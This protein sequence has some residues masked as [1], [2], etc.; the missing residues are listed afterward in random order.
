MEPF[1]R[2]P[3]ALDA[4]LVIGPPADV[5][6]DLASRCAIDATCHKPPSLTA[7]SCDE[8]GQPRCPQL[9]AVRPWSKDSD[10][11]LLSCDTPPST[12]AVPGK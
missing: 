7:C 11:Q 12:D 2:R 9:R 4:T 3:S 10:R 6:N 5:A 1:R 8:P